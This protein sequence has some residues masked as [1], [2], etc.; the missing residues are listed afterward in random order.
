MIQREDG[1]ILVVNKAWQEIS[2]YGQQPIPTVAEWIPKASGP[3]GS[4]VE[5]RILNER[6][7]EGDTKQIFSDRGRLYCMVTFLR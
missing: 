7:A 1:K 4:P 2:G 3:G 6:L 5:S